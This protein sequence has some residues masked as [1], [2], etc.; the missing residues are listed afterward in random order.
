RRAVTAGRDRGGDA[1][2]AV[3]I[4]RRRVAIPAGIDRAVAESDELAELRGGRSGG[5]NRQRRNNEKPN[6]HRQSRRDCD[7]LAHDDG[8]RRDLSATAGTD[9]AVLAAPLPS[10]AC[11]AARRAIGTRNG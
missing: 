8:T 3:G 6:R 2:V 1:L 9:H 5:S 7:N 11:A 4:A 10:A